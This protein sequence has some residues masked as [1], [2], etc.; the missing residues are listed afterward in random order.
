MTNDSSV[1][2]QPH[3]LVGVIAFG[4]LVVAILG[5]LLV[6]PRTL[7]RDAGSLAHGDGELSLMETRPGISSLKV[8]SY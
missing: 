2:R 7:R 4:L 8:K 1:E 5:Y 3:Y 6:L